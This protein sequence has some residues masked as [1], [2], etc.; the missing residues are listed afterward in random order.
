MM[1]LFQVLQKKFLNKFQFYSHE[2]KIAIIG[3]GIAGLTFSNFLK[4]TQITNSIYMKKMRACLLM[5]VTEFNYH[6]IV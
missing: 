2:K 4:N 5:R 6:P 1:S 3:A